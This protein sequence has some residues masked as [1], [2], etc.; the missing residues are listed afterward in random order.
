MIGKSCV[1]T[2]YEVERQLEHKQEG[3][4]KK[5]TASVKFAIYLLILPEIKS[6]SKV[7]ISLDVDTK[8][9]I[10]S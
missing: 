8:D 3:K 6:T 5:C 1:W 2:G 7:Q 4:K 10:S 9:Q